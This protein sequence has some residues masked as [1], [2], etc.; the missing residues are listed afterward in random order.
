MFRATTHLLTWGNISPPA[1]LGDFTRVSPCL[2]LDLQCLISSLRFYGSGGLFPT[3]NI[4]AVLIGIELE[5][6]SLTYLGVGAD[7]EL[8]SEDSL[9]PSWGCSLN[10]PQAYIL[11]GLLNL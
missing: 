5:G 11:V 4:A 3:K 7:P 9:G 6:F 1:S 8:F 2:K 10:S